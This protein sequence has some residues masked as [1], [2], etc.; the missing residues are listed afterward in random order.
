MRKT[1]AIETLNA[2][3]MFVGDYSA[4]ELVT[5]EITSEKDLFLCYRFRCKDG[6]V[7]SDPEYEYFEKIKHD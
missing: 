5:M 2:R 3:V 7:K 6:G 4:P 1:T